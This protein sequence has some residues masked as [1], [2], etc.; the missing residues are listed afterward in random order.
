MARV[1]GVLYL[2]V[3]A[4]AL[5]GPL[6]VHS[7]LVVPEDA[8]ATARN[9]MAS[10][11]LFRAGIGSYLV[12]FMSEVALSVILFV[13]LRPVSKTLSLLAAAF[14]LTMTTIHGINLLNQFSALLLISGGGYLAAFEA[15]QLQAL[16]LLLLNA[17][18]IG[19]SI[20]IVFFSFHV[21]FLGYLV[22][23]SGYIPKF[24]GVLLLVAAVSYLLD[25][26]AILLLPG[27]EVTPVYFMVPIGIAEMVFP[28]WLLIKGVKDQQ[29][30]A[31]ETR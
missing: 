28:L 30:A 5:F 4:A 7:N 15:D 26:V 10:E 19:W 16:A 25:G 31:V 12:I 2:I 27:Y 18:E 23:K 21:F 6:Y 3:F 14:R 24:L 8:S 22:Y 20:G 13:L 9:I 1:A 29:P 11:G 17:H